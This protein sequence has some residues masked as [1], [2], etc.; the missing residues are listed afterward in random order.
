ML[1]WIPF[2]RTSVCSTCWSVADTT[3]E[4]FYPYLPGAP[5]PYAC[6]SASLP[7]EAEPYTLERMLD[8]MDLFHPCLGQLI[9]MRTSV[10][11]TG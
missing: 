5:N 10:C 6:S 8:W 4:F 7:G 11:S 2:L 9:T 3:I 1:D